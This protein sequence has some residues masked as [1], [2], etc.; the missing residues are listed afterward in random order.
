MVKKIHH[1][2][3]IGWVG[4]N[5]KQVKHGRVVIYSISSLDYQWSAQTYT[6]KWSRTCWINCGTHPL[7]PPCSTRHH[8]CH[9]FS[10]AFPIFY[11]SSTSA[12]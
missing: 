3:D 6:T 12:Y 2:S 1:V 9:E 5:C 10:Q 4:P 7:H 8:S 11:H